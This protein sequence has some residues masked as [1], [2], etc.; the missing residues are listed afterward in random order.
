MHQMTLHLALHLE[1]TTAQQDA[2][3]AQEE[4]AASE[5]AVVAAG[6]RA[7]EQ[8]L[9]GELELREAQCSVSLKFICKL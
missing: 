6:K 9:H 8:R 3:N 5:L 4:L 1:A 2:E 7:A